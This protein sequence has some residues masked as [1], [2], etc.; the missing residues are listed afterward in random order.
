MGRHSTMAETA[1]G[2]SLDDIAA[3][4][5]KTNKKASEPGSGKGGKKRRPTEKKK[6]IG[7]APAIKKTITKQRKSPAKAGK[8]A[9]R[10]SKGQG[11]NVGMGIRKGGY[12]IT[13]DNKAFPEADVR[14]FC[15]HMLKAYGDGSVPKK[16]LKDAG[17]NGGGGRTLQRGRPVVQVQRKKSQ[18]RTNAA[19]KA[20]S[21]M[22]AEEKIAARNQLHGVKGGGKAVRSGKAAKAKITKA[23]GV[24]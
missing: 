6:K 12:L 8:G 5:Q 9:G 20:E 21:Q 13:P 7:G 23:A 2:M 3:A 24:Q 11:Q 10:S 4:Q 22:T 17:L 18:I 15:Q 1:L 19:F 14:S 16:L